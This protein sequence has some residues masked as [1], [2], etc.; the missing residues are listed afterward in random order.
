MS[1]NAARPIQAT[2][3]QRAAPKVVGITREQHD[4]KTCDPPRDAVALATHNLHL[5][6]RSYQSLPAQLC[7]YNMRMQLTSPGV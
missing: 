7:R 5:G 1:Q 2:V 4:I 3:P 6:E